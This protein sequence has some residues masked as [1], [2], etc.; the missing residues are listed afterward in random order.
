MS[1]VSLSLVLDSMST[2]W[3]SIV[4][5]M[6]LLPLNVAKYNEFLQL[7]SRK[8]ESPLSL[9]SIWHLLSQYLSGD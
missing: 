5:I 4:S 6:S 7:L 2:P 9:I 8:A 1:G 3:E